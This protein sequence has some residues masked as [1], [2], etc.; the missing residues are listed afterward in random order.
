MFEDGWCEEVDTTVNN[1]T[2]ECAGLFHVMGD[3]MRDL[4][5]DDTSIVQG[6]LSGCLATEI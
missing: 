6:L 5:L 4:V 3:L 2:D 1:G